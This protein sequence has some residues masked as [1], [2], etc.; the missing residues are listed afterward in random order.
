MEKETPHSYQ[1]GGKV[2]EGKEGG[3]RLLRTK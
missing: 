2:E 3:R 1:L